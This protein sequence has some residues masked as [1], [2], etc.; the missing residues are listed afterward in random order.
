MKVINFF[1]APSS[2]KTTLA[3]KLYSQMKIAR[4]KVEITTEFAKDLIYDKSNAVDDQIFVT[5]T[6]YH[7]LY[8]ARQNGLDFVITD[9]PIMLG[10]VYSNLKTSQP[11]CKQ[12]FADLMFSAF[13]EFNNINIFIKH[14]DVRDFKNYGR[15]HD[16]DTSFK[17]SQDIRKMLDDYKINYIEFDYNQHNKLFELIKNID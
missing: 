3:A 15:R 9:S 11:Y 5:S 13:K 16:K 1:G 6:Q 12:A 17:I 4:L 2:G 7:K 10:V 14:E 8:T